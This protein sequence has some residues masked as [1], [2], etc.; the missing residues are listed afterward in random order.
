MPSTAEQGASR[1]LCLAGPQCVGCACISADHPFNWLFEHACWMQGPGGQ[2]W[3]GPRQRA[4]GAGV[5]WQGAH[6]SRRA[7]PVARLQALQVQGCHPGAPHRQLARPAV[8]LWQ[9]VCSS[10]L[11]SSSASCPN[12]RQLC[13]DSTPI[14]DCE[15]RL[16][17]AEHC[18]CGTGIAAGNCAMLVST[19]SS[20]GS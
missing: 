12:W 16:H 4:G 8:A 10:C 5:A 6:G 2:A 3:Q 1:M 15:P 18:L 17:N 9:G 13:S 14:V 11:L 19:A 7:G 20:L